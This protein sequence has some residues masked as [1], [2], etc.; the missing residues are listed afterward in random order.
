M[1]NLTQ[2]ELAENNAFLRYKEALKVAE[3]LA[4]EWA[5]AA[6]ALGE[7]QESASAPLPKNAE[8][9]GLLPDLPANSISSAPRTACD[10][11]RAEGISMFG[12]VN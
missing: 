10:W 1:T 12:E 3:S 6:R 2:L 4:W 9:N 7:A 8:T 11:L 5:L